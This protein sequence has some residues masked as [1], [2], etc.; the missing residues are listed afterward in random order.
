MQKSFIL[1]ILSIAA[2]PNVLADDYKPNDVCSITGTAAA[3]ACSM[4]KSFGGSAFFQQY[5][6]SFNPSGALYVQY[7]NVIV[8]GAQQL[9]PSKISVQP[10]LSLALV[11]SG[12]SSASAQKYFSAFIDFQ[13]TD[14]SSKAIW[15]QTGLVADAQTGTLTSAAQPSLPYTSPNPSANSG[16]HQYIFLVCKEDSADDIGSIVSRNLDVNTLLKNIQQTQKLVAATYF[17]SQYDGIAINGK[18]TGAQQASSTAT[19]PTNQTSNS[20]QPKSTSPVAVSKSVSAGDASSSKAP[21]YSSQTGTKS[22]A[23][24][25]NQTTGSSDGT[26]S[27]STASNLLH[28]TGNLQGLLSLAVMLIAGLCMVV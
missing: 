24:S 1:T 25:Q 6:S 17:K 5:F 21:A 3:D 23:G 22:S 10:S 18:Q 16:T 9:S 13:E 14:K 7:G 19:I 11:G 12:S 28:N 2:F 4:K 20:A 15:A 26:V 27:Q 8:G